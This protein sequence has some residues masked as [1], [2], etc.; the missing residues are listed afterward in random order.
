MARLAERYADHPAL[1]MWHVNNEY[2]C[3]DAGCYC[4]ASAA[5]F[6]DWLRDRY[7]DLD[8]LNDAWG[9][10]FWSQRYTDWAQVQPPRAT[11]TFGNPTPGAGLPPVL[12]RRA[13]RPLHRRAGR[14][15]RRT[16]GSPGDHQ[17]HG[18][19]ASTHGLLG[20]GAGAGRRLHRPLP[21]RRG[22]G[23]H[24]GL[25]YAADLTRGSPAASGC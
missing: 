22:P 13:A 19:P 16:P 3:H 15:A 17:L 8:A 2:G 6:R 18:R 20:V 23:Q 25:A 11:P 12:L 1:A 24:L 7:G 10:A 21:D 14:A 4:D 5:A 9:T